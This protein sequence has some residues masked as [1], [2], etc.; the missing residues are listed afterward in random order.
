MFL[1]HVKR[2]SE[3]KRNMDYWQC[4]LQLNPFSDNI[5]LFVEQNNKQRA[6]SVEKRSTLAVEKAVYGT[7]FR[8][9]FGLRGKTKQIYEPNIFQSFTNEGHLIWKYFYH[10]EE[11]IKQLVS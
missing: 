6:K 9:R 4:M 8:V 3:S 2:L 7:K 5:L 11:F 1:V 10:G